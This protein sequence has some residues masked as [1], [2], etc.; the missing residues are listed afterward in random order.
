SW[1]EMDENIVRERARTFGVPEEG[2][3]NWR[4]RV[5]ARNID[6]EFERLLEGIDRLGLRDNTVVMLVADHGEGLGRAG[7]WVHSVFLWETLVRVP[8][9]IRIPGIEPQVIDDIVS[10][11]DVAPTLAPYLGNVDDRRGY[12]GVDLLAYVA[13]ERPERKHPLV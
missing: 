3:L 13:G 9:G 11:V 6:A 4:Y 10:L 8:L 7:F 12:Q 1:R 2:E 5:I